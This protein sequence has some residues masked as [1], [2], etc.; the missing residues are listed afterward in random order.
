MKVTVRKL[1]DDPTNWVY[2]FKEMI[3]KGEKRMIIDCDVKKVEGVLHKVG[4]RI[5]IVEHRSTIGR[6][7]KGGPNSDMYII[8]R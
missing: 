7:N 4:T 3:D 6:M 1:D 5:W 8:Y 2:M